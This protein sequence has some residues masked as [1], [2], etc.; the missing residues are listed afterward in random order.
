MNGTIWYLKR[1]DLFDRLSDAEADHLN[2][3]A[4][5]RRFPRRTLVYAPT[6]PGESVM[7]LASGRV[8]IKDLTLDGRESIL[9]FI[10]EGEL[11]G[12]MALLEGQPRQEYAET[13]EDSQVLLL[14]RE[15]LLALMESRTDLTLSI[16]KLMG[17]R[18]Q[19]V[20]NRLRNVLFLSSRERMVRLLVELAEAHGQPV[21]TRTEI[22]FPLSHQELASLIGVSRE[23]ATITLGQ[24]EQAGLVIV[25][26]RRVSI[27]SMCRLQAEARG[28]ADATLPAHPARGRAPES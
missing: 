21:G 6:Q 23:T 12:E 14:P 26:R 19:R 1:C 28:Q 11:F 22:R 4:L 9:A 16:T 17:L 27:S 13:V 2:R 25:Q 8:K 18:R 20:E 24:L 15:D 7:V 10:E 3:R 5:V